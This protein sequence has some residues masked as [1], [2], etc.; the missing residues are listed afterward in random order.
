MGE[1]KNL[2]H[3]LYPVLIEKKRKY[4]PGL[5]EMETGKNKEQSMTFSQPFWWN[6]I[7]PI[8]I[9]VALVEQQTLQHSGLLHL[10]GIY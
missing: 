8:H 1:K 10:R 4:Q 2:S 3:S 7:F 6:R 5:T 9:S